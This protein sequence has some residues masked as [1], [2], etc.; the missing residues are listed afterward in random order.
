MLK[1]LHLKLCDYIFDKLDSLTKENKEASILEIIEFIRSLNTENTDNSKFADDI[2]KYIDDHLDSEFS[3]KDIAE[4]FHISLYYMIHL[5]KKAT[6]K[7]IVE[8]KNNPLFKEC[9]DKDIVFH[10]SMPPV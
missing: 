9:M 10:S 4:H 8:Y 2:K 3:D 7:T 6:V 5:F 1:Q